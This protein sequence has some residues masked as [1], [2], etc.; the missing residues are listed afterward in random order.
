MIF[1]KGYS[2]YIDS[3]NMY[4]LQAIFPYAPYNYRVEIISPVYELEVNKDIKKLPEVSVVDI[5]SWLLSLNEY[6]GDENGLLFNVANMLIQVAKQSISYEFCGSD[7]QYKRVI[8]LYVGHYL[9]FHFKDVKDEEHNMS[10]Q[11]KL[12]DETE[13]DEIKKLKINYDSFIGEYKNTIYGRQ[14]WTIYGQH[15]KFLL[16]Y[17][18]Y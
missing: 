10:F 7:E 18:P 15:A 14:F 1:P 9:D 17:A 3:E 6:L 4:H 13:T 11:P 8:A 12:K 2:Y 16:G 5:K